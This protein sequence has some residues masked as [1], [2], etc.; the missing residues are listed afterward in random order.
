MKFDPR[1]LP[2]VLVVI[3][4]LAAFGY[5]AADGVAEWRRPPL[6]CAAD[7][8]HSRHCPYSA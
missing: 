4:V 2:T 1:I 6:G 5:F 7:E 8:K 3:D